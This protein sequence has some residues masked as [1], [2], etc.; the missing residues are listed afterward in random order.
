[1]P[2]KKV[3]ARPRASS[4]IVT[5]AID[6]SFPPLGGGQAQGL[7]DAGVLQ[8]GGE[9]YGSLAREVIQNSLDA[10]ESNDKPVRVVF[11]LHLLPQSQ[12]P[13]HRELRKRCENCRDF[14]DRPNSKE[15]MFFRDAVKELSKLTINVLTI[16]DHNTVGVEGDDEH[17]TNPPHWYNL[18]RCSG[19]SSKAA[20]AAGSF[21]IGKNAP[22]AAS[23]LR[24][25]F[26]STRTGPKSFRF[27][28]VAKLV[29]HAAANRKHCQA[30]GFL[31][32]GGKAVTSISQLPEHFRRSERGTTLHVIGFRA[33]ADWE[34]ALKEA[35]I[36]NFWLAI[37]AGKLECEIQG[38][39][40]TA[41]TLDKQVNESDALKKA[42][43]PYLLAF[44]RGS[45]I[46]SVLERLGECRLYLIS[47]RDITDDS[48]VFPKRV[49]MTRLSGMLIDTPRFNSMVPYAGV[50][51]CLDPE[52]NNVLRDMEPPAHDKWDPD[53][54]ER[55]ANRAT[56]QAL[57]DFVRTHVQ[58]LSQVP[59][60]ATLELPSLSKF[61]PD[62]LPANHS[63]SKGA[64]RSHDDSVERFPRAE[65]DPAPVVPL[66][67]KMLSTSASRQSAGAPSSVE[68][69]DLTSQYAEREQNSES[70][71]LPEEK[72]G[73]RPKNVGGV[74]QGTALPLRYRAFPTTRDGADYRLIVES[75]YATA[76]LATLQLRIVGEAK[77]RPALQI[78]AAWDELRQPIPILGAGRLGPINLQPGNSSKVTLKLKAVCRYALEVSAHAH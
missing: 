39:T 60:T 6:W 10:A 75:K 65:E 53:L 22:F 27:A 76:C 38:E 78:D 61:L 12:I 42:V 52:G 50:F 73:E 32:S 37:R 20:G 23:R 28:G 67:K 19:S 47:K 29:T 57:Q 13:G 51:C 43:G 69:T 14:W 77:D 55:G 64:Q 68:E 63:Q 16:S 31:E 71:P 25:I 17:N 7:N 58:K 18:V 1:M 62:V 4:G 21:G 59:T 34:R 11:G 5:A 48:V 74:Q 56:K 35:V 72:A 66:R 33:D 41:S 24:T 54:P 49:F 2:K 36:K 8:F 15:K 44:D 40:I 30:T 46:V 3:K 26:Y 70:E 9:T 45:P